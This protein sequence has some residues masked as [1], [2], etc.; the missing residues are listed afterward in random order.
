MVRLHL[1]LPGVSSRERVAADVAPTSLSFWG[2]EHMFRKHFTNKG[3]VDA[4]VGY[5]G[6]TTTDPNYRQV[7]S[8]STNHAEAVKLEFDPSKVS[9]AEL[10]EFHYRMH[11]PS[12]LSG[13]CLYQFE[14]CSDYRCEGAR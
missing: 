14:E 13:A 9:F 11:D 10:T 5:I 1:L 8:G 7:C 2:T 4:K 3:L 6:G 12:T